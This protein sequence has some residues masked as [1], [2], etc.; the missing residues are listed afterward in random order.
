MDQ[1]R[2]EAQGPRT[3][4][5][6]GELDLA[7]VPAMQEAL[8]G[9]ARGRGPVT[10]DMAQVTFIDSSGMRAILTALRELE[11][12]CIILHGVHG[13]VQKTLDIV[14]IEKAENL[15]ILSCTASVA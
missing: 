3:F 13:A 2:I 5:L 6:E 11:A 14:G 8:R 12:D 4:F 15:H 7:T 1:F 10:L 9:A